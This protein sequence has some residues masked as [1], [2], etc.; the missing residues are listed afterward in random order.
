MSNVPEITN[1]KLIKDNSF[2][3]SAVKTLLSSAGFDVDQLNNALDIRC[4]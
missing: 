4:S 3:L 2:I 1:F